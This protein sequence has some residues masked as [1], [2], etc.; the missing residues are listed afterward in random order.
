MGTL[1]S[2]MAKIT[3][4]SVIFSTLFHFYSKMNSIVLVIGIFEHVWILWLIL[5]IIDS[6][7]N[8]QNIDMANEMLHSSTI[9]KYLGNIKWTLHQPTW[10]ERESV[11]TIFVPQFWYD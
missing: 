6:R 4:P 1:D 2:P 3:P 7:K 9:K 11:D 10:Y 5:T 8:I